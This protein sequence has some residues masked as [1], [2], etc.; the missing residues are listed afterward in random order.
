MDR[1]DDWPPPAPELERAYRR[2][3][4][5]Y[6]GS[7]R[8]RHGTEILT[9][10]LEMAEPGRRRPPAA[11]AWHLI[12]SGI[13][14]RFRLPAAR[15]LAWVVA[16]LAALIGGGFGAAAGSWAAQQ[17]LTALPDRAGWQQL[18]QLVAP[19][20]SEYFTGLHD[21]STYFAPSYVSGIPVTVWD[22]ERARHELAAA[23]W[24]VETAQ[25]VTGLVGFTDPITG[26]DSRVRVT[27]YRFSAE[28]GGLVLRT[29]GWAY[30][31]RGSVNLMLWQQDNGTLLPL[32]LAGAV[33]GMI[34]GWLLTASG[35]RRLRRPRAPRPSLAER[36]IIAAA[37]DRPLTQTTPGHRAPQLPLVAGTLTCLTVAAFALPVSALYGN[38]TGVLI[39]DDDPVTLVTVHSA[40]SIGARWPFGPPWLN[41]ALT[42]TGLALTL[43]TFLTLRHRPEPVPATTI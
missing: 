39:R 15:P 27:A 34:A 22:G 33:T 8:R 4:L 5:A 19:G 30:N 42:A 28:R 26:A 11:D 3:L 32:S 37:L 2:L 43:I 35:F 12:G 24:A 21:D 9:L 31:R 41:A 38:L 6:P 10:L 13:R 36:V 23:G 14:Q 20:G 7:Y 1:I 40:L 17:S 29:Q 25:P 18:A 16:L